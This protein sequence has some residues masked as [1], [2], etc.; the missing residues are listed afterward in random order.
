[1]QLQAPFAPGFDM[2]RGYEPGMKITYDPK[3]KRVVV[4]FR[5][6][7]TVLPDLFENE[8]LAIAG[9]EHHCRLLGWNAQDKETSKRKLRS[10]W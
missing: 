8:E 2:K 7:I 10:L 1:M 6:R 3:S 9:G 5:G 4:A